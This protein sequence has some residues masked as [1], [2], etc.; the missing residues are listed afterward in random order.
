MLSRG[1]GWTRHEDHETVLRRPGKTVSQDTEFSSL[2]N[3]IYK[4]G[5]SS[6]PSVEEVNEIAK[7]ITSI[8]D[9][10]KLQQLIEQLYKQALEDR[11]FGIKLAIVLSDKYICCISNTDTMLRSLL[12][13]AMQSDFNRK[14]ELREQNKQQFL[15]AVS[16]LGEI[17]YRFRLCGTPVKVL[18]IPL[19]NYMKMLLET[20]SEEDIE[21]ATTQASINGRKIYEKN[22]VELEQFLINVRT[23][24]ITRN[25]SARSR[26]MLLFILDLANQRYCPLSGDLQD[27]YVEQLGTKVLI[28]IQR[29]D[30]DLTINTKSKDRNVKD[31]GINSEQG[32]EKKKS[33]KSK[34][35]TNSTNNTIGIL[36]RAPKNK[37]N[38][39]VESKTICSEQSTT[40]D[41]QKNTYTDQKGVHGDHRNFQANACMKNFSGASAPVPR[42]IRGSGVADSGKEHKNDKKSPRGKKDKLTDEQVWSS[43]QVTNSK[44]WGHDDRF[45]KDYN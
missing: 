28:Q 13:T 37:G 5:L 45:E 16:F 35:E 1:R 39:Q 7:L 32:S 4:L 2:V 25:L 9:N 27:F 3:E 23:V 8:A 24:L 40:V 6:S 18:A 17:Y 15:N 38:T 43:K 10:N 21:L 29:H 33:E 11:D 26:G 34:P 42:A 31:S 14:E 22:Q 36:M 30:E 44:V 12:L 19:L 41:D 20:A